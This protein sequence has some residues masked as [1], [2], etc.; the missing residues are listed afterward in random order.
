[1]TALWWQLAERRARAAEAHLAAT[2]SWITTLAD[3]LRG[4]PPPFPGRGAARVAAGGPDIDALRRAGLHDPVREILVDL[5]THPELIP[6]PGIEGGTMRFVVAESRLV[7]N[8]WAFGYFEDGHIAGHGIF[9]YKLGPGGK[10]T[11]KRLAA[12]LD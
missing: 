4:V 6:F 12:M 3:S 5:S 10:I 2:E 8:E 9:E 1:M 11:W 7:S